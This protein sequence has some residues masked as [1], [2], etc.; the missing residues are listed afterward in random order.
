MLLAGG[1]P[2]VLKEIPSVTPG[3][4]EDVLAQ[5]SSVSAEAVRGLGSVVARPDWQMFLLQNWGWFL[6]LAIILILLVL[7]K[8]K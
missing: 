3:M 5:G 6:L 7:I 8:R 4:V 2:S 1:S